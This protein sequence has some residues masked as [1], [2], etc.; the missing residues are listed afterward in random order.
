MGGVAGAKNAPQSMYYVQQSR[1]QRS[2]GGTTFSIGKQGVRKRVAV[3]RE[4]QHDLEERENMEKR[5]GIARS[6]SSW[7]MLGILGFIAA[8]TVQFQNEFEVRGTKVCDPSPLGLIRYEERL[9][10]D[11]L[12]GVDTGPIPAKDIGNPGPTQYQMFEASGNYKWRDECAQT[13]KSALSNYTVNDFFCGHPELT[14][15]RDG[16]ETG[17][18]SSDSALPPAKFIFFAGAVFTFC[19]LAEALC[20]FL[21]L[22]DHKTHY[23][24]IQTVYDHIS[25]LI[26]RQSHKVSKEDVRV[27]GLVPEPMDIPRVVQGLFFFFLIGV[28]NWLVSNSFIAVGLGFIVIASSLVNDSV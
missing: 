18:C 25:A 27:P 19:Q 21:T 2:D 7:A 9:E 13:D 5:A 3:W 16:K 8:A 11:S 17:T 1:V 20:V 6:V 22:R 23:H 4:M 24:E 28:G 15:T 12:E 10:A 14:I 26:E